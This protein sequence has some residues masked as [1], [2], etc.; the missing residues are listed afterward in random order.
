MAP[1]VQVESPARATA[2]FDV[3]KR[4][5]LRT[6]SSVMTNASSESRRRLVCLCPTRQPTRWRRAFALADLGASRARPAS[7][8]PEIMG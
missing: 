7:V 4:S 2:P 6:S 5:A 8:A 3:G 1:R